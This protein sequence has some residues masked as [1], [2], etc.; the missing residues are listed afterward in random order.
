M[1][2]HGAAG[3]V[4]QHGQQQGERYYC[5]GKVTHDGY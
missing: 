1:L 5:G 4:A 2:R 3:P